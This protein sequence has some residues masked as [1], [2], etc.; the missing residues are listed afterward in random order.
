MIFYL[1]KSF[2]ERVIEYPRWMFTVDIIALIL[3]LLIG[4]YL[5]GCYWG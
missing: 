4:V 5:C 2:I 1:C 3:F